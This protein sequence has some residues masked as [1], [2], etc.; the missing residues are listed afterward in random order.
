MGE[1]VGANKWYIRQLGV[2]NQKAS[3]NE[4]ESEKKEKY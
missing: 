4:L 2:N 3:G 1:G